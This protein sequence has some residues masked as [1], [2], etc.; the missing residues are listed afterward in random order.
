MVKFLSHKYYYFLILIFSISFL[1]F[2]VSV[3]RADDLDNISGYALDD[4]YGWVS[5]NCNNDTSGAL[6][7]FGFTLPFELYRYTCGSSHLGSG[8]DYGVNIDEDGTLSGFAW[9]D[10]AGWI[11]FSPETANPPSYN[12]TSHLI[13][14]NANIISLGT[15]GLLDL[16]GGVSDSI[17]I[18]PTTGDWLGYGWNSTS[19]FMSMNCQNDLSCGGLSY[20]VNYWAVLKLGQ[21]SAPNWNSAEACSSSGAKKAIFKWQLTR[22][23]MTDYQNDFQIIIDDDSIMD[24]DTPAWDSGKITSSATQYSCPNSI[25]ACSLDYDTTYYFWVRFWDSKNR[26]LGWIQFDTDET[27]HYLTDNVG[28]NTVANPDDSNFTLTTYKHEFPDVDY[29][30]DPTEIIIGD[31]A[32]FTDAS[33][34]YTS[35]NPGGS[36]VTCNDVDCGL[37]W[38]TTSSADI[39]SPTSSVTDVTFFS[40]SSNISLSVTDPDGYTCSSVTSSLDINFNLPDW[41]EIKAE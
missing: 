2:S 19:Q 20:F 29:T 18:E 30:W 28:A 17:S 16:T 39:D 10:T 24:D 26:V 36:P 9:N 40:P 23:G 25:D 14:G 11:D 31:I 32:T 8:N 5:F 15:S 21:L 41:R 7:G 33:Q 34:Y 37:L 12:I 6:D 35:A 27:N 22:D 38:S 13:T 3:L 4:T 1:F